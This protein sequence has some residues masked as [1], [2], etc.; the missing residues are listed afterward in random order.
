MSMVWPL[1]CV[2][3]CQQDLH[4]LCVCA[5]RNPNNS[6]STD[7]IVLLSG[8]LFILCCCCCCFTKKASAE[9]LDVVR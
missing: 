4:C 9:K 6:F 2:K 8:F 3:K 1:A 5:E 7:A